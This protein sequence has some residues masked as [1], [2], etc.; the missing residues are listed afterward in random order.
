MRFR[1]AS[2]GRGRHDRGAPGLADRHAGRHDGQHHA[3]GRLADFKDV[4]LDLTNPPTGTH[5]LFLVFRNRGSTQNLFNVNWFDVLGK[6]AATTA[7]PEVERSSPSPLGLGPADGPVHHDRDRPRRRQ[8]RADVRV[9]LRRP[10]HRRRRL[11]AEEPGYTYPAARHLQ[12]RADGHRR[13]R[14]RDHQAGA[15]H[16]QPV[17]RVPDRRTATTSTAPTWPRRGPSCGATRR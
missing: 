11:D 2:R 1:V 4:S 14:R 16:G 12:R 8:R 17:Q 13:R 3:D 6:G 5:E 7:A 9:G 15:D 10:R